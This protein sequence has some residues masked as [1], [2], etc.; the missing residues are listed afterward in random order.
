VSGI[1]FLSNSAGTLDAHSFYND[2]EAAEYQMLITIERTD[3]GRKIE[4][5]RDRSAEIKECMVLPWAAALGL[6]KE[7]RG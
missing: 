2:K 1:S 6:E 7:P 5:Q 4:T 3:R